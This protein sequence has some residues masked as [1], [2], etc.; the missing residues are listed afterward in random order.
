MIE[1]ELSK[2]LNIEKKVLKPFKVG[3][4]IFYPIVEIITL[5]NE[6]SFNSLNIS[7]VAFLVKENDIEYVI[8]VIEDEID[9]LK[10]QEFIELAK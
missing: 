7:P 5:G 10:L 3:D 1:I 9:D 4:R 8:P 2:D 6:V